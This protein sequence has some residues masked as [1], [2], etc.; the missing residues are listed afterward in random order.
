MTDYTVKN[1]LPVAAALKTAGLNF[2]TK[3]PALAAKLM[4]VI[5]EAELN[6]VQ[7]ALQDYVTDV[8][9]HGETKE[10]T[11]Q[12]LQINENMYK[13]MERGCLLSNLA[14]LVPTAGLSATDVTMLNDLGFKRCSQI[15]NFALPTA[16]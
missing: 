5:T 12:F 14:D 10:N 15:L 3:K 1:L 8:A 9:A 11:M 2:K 6:G 13:Y 16:V 4:S 7:S